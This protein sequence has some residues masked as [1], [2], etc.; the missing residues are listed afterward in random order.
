MA[1]TSISFEETPLLALTLRRADD[2]LILG[3]RLSEW[4]SK[5]PTLEEDIALSNMALDLI[6][7]ARMLFDYASEQSQ[8]RFS[9]DDF[10]F[11][12]ESH[13]FRNCLLMEQPNGDFAETMMRHVFVSAFM[14]PYWQAMMASKDETLAAI[15]GKAEKEWAYHLRHASDWVIRL[16]D[17]TAESHRRTQRAADALWVYTGEL[18]ELDDKERALVGTGVA[19][20]PETLRPAWLKTVTKIFDEATLAMPQSRWMQ[21]GGRTGRHSEHLGRLLAEMQSLPRTYPGARW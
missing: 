20:D 6:G 14:Y 3:H 5:A 2:A 7:Q 8:R 11:L 9:E 18:L 13:Q 10:A 17:G 19:V 16:G 12:R 1:T 21:G 15:A 4:S